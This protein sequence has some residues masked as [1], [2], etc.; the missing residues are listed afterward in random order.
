MGNGMR[1][2]DKNQPLIINTKSANVAKPK[3]IQMGLTGKTVNEYPTVP[4]LERIR[5]IMTDQY[6]YPLQS[7]FGQEEYKLAPGVSIEQAEK[8][9]QILTDA[10]DQMDATLAKIPD[11]DEAAEAYA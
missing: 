11:T 9:A 2:F 10:A 5:E 1:S 6:G 7:A 3:L 8:Y 4:A